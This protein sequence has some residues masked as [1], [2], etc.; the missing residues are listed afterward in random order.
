MWMNAPKVRKVIGDK[1]MEI[2][3]PAT[4]CHASMKNFQLAVILLGLAVDIKYFG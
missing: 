3:L 1:A 2:H 4:S